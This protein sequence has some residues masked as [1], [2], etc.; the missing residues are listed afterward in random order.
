MKLLAPVF[1]LLATFY[2]A[3]AQVGIGTTSPQSA[4]DISVKNPSNPEYTDGL[5]IPRLDALPSTDPKDEQHGMLIYLT[6]TSG[7]KSPG[8]HYWDKNQGASGEWIPLE[9][10]WKINGNSNAT[11]GTHFIGTTNAQEVDFRVNNTHIA[12]FTELGQLE[13]ESAGESVLIGIE[14]GENY[15]PSGT[16]AEQN[17]FIGYH[18]ARASTSGRDN[19]AVGAYSMTSNTTGNFNVAVGDETLENNTTG[20]DNTALG[21]DALRANDDG[22]SNSAI[23]RDALRNNVTGDNNTSIG[24]NSLDSNTA[25]NNTAVGYDAGE[26]N[27]TGSSNTYVGYDADATSGSISNSMALGN[28][29]RISSSNQI[30]VGNTSIT[31]IGGYRSWSNLSDARFKLNVQENVPGLDFILNI[32][33]VTY[34]LN[35]EKLSAFKGETE[36]VRNT[37]EVETGFLAQQIEEVA[38]SMGY[39]FSGVTRPD[40]LNKDNYTVSYATFVVPLVKAVQ[41]Q[42]SEIETLRAEIEE[43]KALIKASNA[44]N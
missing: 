10:D 17:V 26:S 30:R 12:R 14:A 19:V 44:G 15:D 7:T 42:Q 43:L 24:R 18:A 38:Q 11:R 29:A 20:S 13:L 32:K 21:N 22:Q 25:S 36:V 33:P 28:G 2:V 27:T 6:T 16:A 4:L 8:F 40:D 35:R 37:S 1:A 5:L 3:N 34:T 41:E 39:E 31:S 9:N 23:G